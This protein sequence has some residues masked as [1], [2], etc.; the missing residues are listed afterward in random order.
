MKGIKRISLLLEKGKEYER[1][2]L[3]LKLKKEQAQDPEL[4]SQPQI[5]Y[6]AATA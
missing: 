5:N 3:E 4:T 2:K 1:R 6:T